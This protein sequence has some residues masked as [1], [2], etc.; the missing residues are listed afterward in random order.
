MTAETTVPADGYDLDENYLLVSKKGTIVIRAYVDATD[1]YKAAEKN[2][3][4]TVLGE[5]D[6]AVIGY[7]GSTETVDWGNTYTVETSIIEGGDITL[8]TDNEQIFSISGLV[9]TPLAVGS[10]TITITTAENNE[11]KA[12][13]ADFTLTV[14][15]PTESATAPAGGD[16]TTT[17][18]DKDFAYEGDGMSWTSAVEGRSFESS[19]SARG[20]QIGAAKGEYTINSST[21][22][23]V[24]KVSMVV[25]TNSTGNTLAVSVGGNDFVYTDGEGNESTSLSLSKA[26]DQT[27]EFT[28]NG[29]GNIVIAVNNTAKTVWFK[30]ITVTTEAVA[31]EVTLAASGYATYCSEYPLDLSTLDT[32]VARAWYV[33]NVSDNEVTFEEITGSI[34]GNTP[35]ILYGTAGQTVQLSYAPV[36]QPAR[37]H[38]C[39]HMGIADGRHDDQLRFEWWFV[40]E[41]QRWRCACK[42]G[43]SACDGQQC[44]SAAHRLCR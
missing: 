1:E 38:P 5:K 7:E 16:V 34:P 25:S 10:A 21:S 4:I 20:V 37:R 2:T 3:T 22:A 15:A 8:S 11:Y 18:T 26:N 40:C 23:N 36:G 12:G 39:S 42:Q 14:N 31:P 44:T 32:D 33:S 28:G 27:I 35:F 19:G 17:F 29:T 43:L 13:T 30:S 6:D 24:T 9:I 41:D